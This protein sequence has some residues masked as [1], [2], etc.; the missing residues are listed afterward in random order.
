MEESKVCTKCGVRKGLGEFPK[1]KLCLDGHAG[2][3]KKCNK[4]Y[5]RE[6]HKAHKGE[7][8]RKACEYYGANKVEALRK[9]REF[10]EKHPLEMRKLDQKYSR[11]YYKN[12]KKEHAERQRAYRATGKGWLAM[13]RGV[14]KRRAKA[15]NRKATLTADQWQKTIAAQRKRCNVCGKLFSQNS[16]PTIDHIIPLSKGGGLT[17]ENVQALCQ[18]CNS[19]KNAKLDPQFI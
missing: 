10:R 9:Q 11:K 14:H 5:K 1:H 6:Y 15:K 19:S 17:F 3:C 16:I 12:H 13:K 8:N 18:S 2:D 7:A 4:K